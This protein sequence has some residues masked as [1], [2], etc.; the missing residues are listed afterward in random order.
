MDPL[1]NALRPLRTWGPFLALLVLAWALAGFAQALRRHLSRRALQR[2]MARARAG[3]LAAEALLA[4]HGY[5]VVARQVPRELVLVV[6]GIALPYQVRADLLVA[7]AADERFVAEVK[8]GSQA[9]D[10]LHV[11]TRRQLLEY[12]LAF[13]DQRGVLLVDM[14]RRR[15]RR[16]RFARA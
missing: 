1:S 11:P 6:D 5:R 7:S 4:A 9:S 13:P 12:A 14:E 3:E 15:L 8:T 10:P 16:V 2:R